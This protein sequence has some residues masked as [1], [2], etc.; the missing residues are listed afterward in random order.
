MVTDV[1]PGGNRGVA[2]RTAH[3]EVLPQRHTGDA[4]KEAPGLSSCVQPPVLHL[5]PDGGHGDGKA[6]I[7]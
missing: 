7:R 6:D 4:G 2:E 3:E 5:E 1:A